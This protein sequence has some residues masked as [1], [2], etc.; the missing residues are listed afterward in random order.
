MPTSTDASAYNDRGRSAVRPWDI[1]L[2]GWRDI[3]YR[4]KNEV[5]HDNISIV[6]A[7]VAFYALLAIFPALAA[8]IGLYGLVADPADVQKEIEAL[9]NIVPAEAHALLSRQLNDIASHA[10]T[11]LSLSVL[12]GLAVA[13]W[14]ATKGITSLITALNIVYNEQEKRS[15]LKLNGLALAFTFGGILFALVAIGLIAGLPAF[16]SFT[17]LRGFLSFLFSLL[18]WPLL[19]LAFIF[20]LAVVYHYGPCRN[21]PRWQWISPG[22]VLAVVL[23]LIG[24]GLFSFYV[25]NFGNY[26]ETYGS[27]GAIVILLTWFYLTAY[28]V[29][30]GAE[31]NAEMEHQTKEDTTIGEPEPL[32]ERRA[33][34]ADTIGKAYGDKGRDNTDDSRQHPRR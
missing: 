26:N 29:L 5:V 34:V 24:S 25:S 16:L 19:A 32:G 20:G 27:V 33:Y 22:A 18:R 1:P 10:N 12:I 8:M 14:S 30:L 31:L 17:G 15:F 13:I 28:V 11:A 2:A 23:W 7:G 3:A 6:A 4:V 21:A 9:A